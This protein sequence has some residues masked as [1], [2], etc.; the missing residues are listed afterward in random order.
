M[1]ADVPTG[2][3]P[4]SDEP[5]RPTATAA[6]RRHLAGHSGIRSGRYAPLYLSPALAVFLVFAFGP[7]IFVLYIS[8]FQWNLLEPSLSH[9]IGVANYQ[10]LFASPA[11][12]HSA[13]ISAYFV[14]ASVVLSTVAGL[15]L[16]LLL[17]R[18][19]TLHKVVRLAVFSPYFTPI[20]ATSIV[21]VWIFNP[22]FGLLDALLKIVH[23][24][25]VGWLESVTWAMP[26]ILLYTMWHDIGFTVI[27]FLA[28][29][30]AVSVELR[31]AA[32]VDGASALRETWHVVLPQITGTL[33]FVIVITTVNSLQAFTQFYTMTGGGPVNATTTTG[34]L[35]YQNAFVFYNT[36]YGA[37]MAVVLFIVIALVSL[38]QFW[39][40]RRRTPA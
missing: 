29:L 30:A 22:Q 2:P 31:E 19:R 20:V 6:L 3:H 33:L 34:Y 23:L 32:R 26:A 35:V 14:V 1:A 11:F 27:I 16:A 40:L 17:L 12:W 7:A 10:T 39:L 4:P 15:G 5:M 13:L 8:F 18:Q 36:G 25:A 24:P 37:A 38:S 21:W 9:F 28:G